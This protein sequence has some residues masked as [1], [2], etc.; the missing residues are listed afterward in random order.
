MGQ[1]V[2]AKKRNAKEYEPM[3]E[4]TR[5]LLQVIS[6]CCRGDGGLVAHALFIESTVCCIR[7]MGRLV[8]ACPD[9]PYT[10]LARCCARAGVHEHIH[11]LNCPLHASA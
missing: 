8:A 1:V 2:K 11:A 9:V 3:L 7:Y 4:E 10:V 5:A 6:C